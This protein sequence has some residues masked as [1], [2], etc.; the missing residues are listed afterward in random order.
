[1][2]FSRLPGQYPRSHASVLLSLEEDMVGVRKAK[3]PRYSIRDSAVFTFG[4][5]VRSE[6]K[7]RYNHSTAHVVG[8]VDTLRDFSSTHAHQDA[9]GRFRHSNKLFELRNSI[10]E[11]T[12]CS[13]FQYNSLSGK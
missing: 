10:I 7:T 1:M 3:K 12:G 5:K 9:A 13:R 2:E 11:I 8:K 4:V 6:R